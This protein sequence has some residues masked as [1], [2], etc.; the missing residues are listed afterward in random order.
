MQMAY[1]D[2][3][4]ELLPEDGFFVDEVTQVG[5]VSWYGFPVYHPRHFITA[6]HQGTLGYGYA[7]ALGVAVA[8]PG[9]KVVQVSGDGGFMF[10]VQELSTAVQNQLNVVTV[11]FNDQTFTNVQRQQDE[12]FEG[13]RI[14]SDLHNPDFVKLAES[15]GAT[16]LHADSPQTLRNTLERAFNTDG[17]VIIEVSVAQRMDS[18][19][20]FIMMPQNRKHLCR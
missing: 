11:I 7:T 15:F 5:F 4:R 10:N 8:N 17:P 20:Q 14:C 16:G 6:G 13:R 12:W 3:I 19:W 9:K 18:P 2:V 1:L